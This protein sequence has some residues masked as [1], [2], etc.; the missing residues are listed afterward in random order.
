MRRST[1]GTA[2]AIGLVNRVVPD[3]DLSDETEAMAR[4]IAGRSRHTIALG[5][6]AFH[7]QLEMSLDEAYAHASAVMVDNLLAED[8]REGIDAFIARRPPH[9]SDR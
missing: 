6:R 5:K 4:A 2:Q 1:A 7:A 9:W 8:A 3:A